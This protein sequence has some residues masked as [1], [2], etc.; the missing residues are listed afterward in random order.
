MNIILLYF[1]FLAG[2]KMMKAIKS[3]EKQWII[4]SVIQFIILLCG[5]SNNDALEL[6]WYDTTFMGMDVLDGGNLYSYAEN[7]TYD[8]GDFSNYKATIL[9]DG[10]NFTDASC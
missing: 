3:R 10:G 4:I 2:K 7:D 8:G 1:L 6:I 9:F 5:I